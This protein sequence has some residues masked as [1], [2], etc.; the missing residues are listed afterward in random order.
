MRRLICY[1]SLNRNGPM[2]ATFAAYIFIPNQSVFTAGKPSSSVAA[3][4]GPR[5]QL[6]Q[7]DIS[8]A[9]IIALIAL[10]GFAFLAL[11]DRR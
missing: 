11:T 3:P 9:G 6:T 4:S 7:Q 1:N 8:T 10:A 2:P 5:P